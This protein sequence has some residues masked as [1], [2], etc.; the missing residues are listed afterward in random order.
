KKS[1]KSTEKFNAPKG[2]LTEQSIEVSIP[3]VHSHPERLYTLQD[4]EFD[5]NF[6]QSLFHSKS[7][8]WLDQIVFDSSI[9]LDNPAEDFLPK[10]NQDDSLSIP[11]I[12]Y[13]IYLKHRHLGETQA[14]F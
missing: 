1:R 9:S 2:Q 14:I 13:R 12:S 10:V 7:L 5:I 3:R 8:S 4:I 11:L 6:E